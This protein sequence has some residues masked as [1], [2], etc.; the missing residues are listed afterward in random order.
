MGSTAIIYAA[1]AVGLALACLLA[2]RVWGRSNVQS[3]VEDAVEAARKSADAREF[4]LREQ[5]DQKMTEVAK[6]VP[7][8]DEAGRLRSQLKH[9]KKN[10]IQSPAEIDN[11]SI[12]HASVDQPGPRNRGAPH[13]R[14][15][16]G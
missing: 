2:G 6:L 15:I 13:A 16:R 12:I 4:T 1:V 11:A 3:Q 9:Q 5:L 14:R 10:P 8:A 7:L